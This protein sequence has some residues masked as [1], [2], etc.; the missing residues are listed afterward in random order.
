MVL[1]VG[2]KPGSLSHKKG[3]GGTVV[4]IEKGFWCGEVIASF[5][6]GE[7]QDI[8]CETPRVCAEGRVVDGC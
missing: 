7:C 6:G 2:G 3:E 4:P 5:L 8:V 1:G